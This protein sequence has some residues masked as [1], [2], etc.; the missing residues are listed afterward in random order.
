MKCKDI[1][2]HIPDYIAG[3]LD[4]KLRQKFESHIETC[5]GCRN[6]ADTLRVLRNNVG[7][8]PDEKPAA[9]IRARFD[10]KVGVFKMGMQTD[11]QSERFTRSYHGFRLN[12]PAFQAAAAIL[13]FICGMAAGTL[14][15][16]GAQNGDIAAMRDE[17]RNLDKMVTLSLMAQTSPSSR[18]QGINRIYQLEQPDEKILTLLVNTLEYDPNLNVRLA[19]VEALYRFAFTDLIRARLVKSLERQESPMMQIALIDL[20]IELSEKSA[21][22]VFQKML[23]N[24]Y[25]NNIVRKKLESGLETLRSVT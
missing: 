9:T 17:I 15:F 4:N 24:E 6:E 8:L 11:R 20:V 10:E 18:L 23:E 21:V 22:P 12:H 25:L 16:S 13:L 19:S 1:Q 5:S 2:K 14:F 3:E 7:N